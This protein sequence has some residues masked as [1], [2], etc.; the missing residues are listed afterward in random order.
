MP[1]LPNS[2]RAILDVS[3]LEDYC[4]DPAHP[5]GRHKARVFRES[6]NVTRTDAFWLREALLSGLQTN[7]AVELVADR[8]GARWRVDAPI[9][10]QG[11]SVV[12]RT[13]WIV[14]IGES[15]PRFVTC[16]VL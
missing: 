5:R 4:L 9:S 14:R 2:E 3:K 8:F 16:W 1:R 11:K 10:R 15:V 7:D 12:V 13:I 6:I